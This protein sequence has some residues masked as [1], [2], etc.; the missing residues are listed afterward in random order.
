MK[1][2]WREEQKMFQPWETVLTN[3]VHHLEKTEKCKPEPFS[4]GMIDGDVT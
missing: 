4:H 2:K 3:P 1:S